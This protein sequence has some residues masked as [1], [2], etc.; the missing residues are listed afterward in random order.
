MSISISANP[1]SCINLAMVQN[2]FFP[3]SYIKLDSTESYENLTLIVN[4]KNGLTPTQKFYV[5]NIEPNRTY[6]IKQMFFEFD[7]FNLATLTSVIT[8]TLCITVVDSLNNLLAEATAKIEVL[9][10]NVVT[11]LEQQVQLLATY[12]TPQ[13]M[14]VKNL[15]SKIYCY[16][17]A[18]YPKLSNI[19]T[20]ALFNLKN[21][22][23]GDKLIADEKNGQNTSNSQVATKE[24]LPDATSAENS[25]LAAIRAKIK[26]KNV[27]NI[28]KTNLLTKDISFDM[29]IIKN[30]K[31]HKRRYGF[32]AYLSLN[33]KYL[34]LEV[35]SIIEYLKSLNFTLEPLPKDPLD[36]TLIIRQPSEVISSKSANLLELTI[37]FNS[38]LE[39]IGI[40]S[41]IILTS[42]GVYASIW[43][44]DKTAQDILV[45]DIKFLEDLVNKDELIII[46]PKDFVEDNN[47]SNKT[48]STNSLFI[49]TTDLEN[50]LTSNPVT[51]SLANITLAKELL[52]KTPYLYH[53]KSLALIN[54]IEAGFI[55]YIDIAAS[56]SRLLS[57][58]SIIIKNK[59]KRRYHKSNNC[60]VHCQ[61][62]QYCYR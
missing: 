13:D 60:K 12:V 48:S 22:L 3:I 10:A 55:I 17:Q 15:I 2:N 41:G 40:H 50:L 53:D 54:D 27:E 7:I 4:W 59:L 14:E 35:Q 21:I 33:Y 8:D 25:N 49:D 11:G 19:V 56:K 16:H 58:P 57:L 47:D 32:L 46:T 29:E 31:D 62:Q 1:V 5:K 45:D 43:L 36:N 44:K 39:G 9:P 23:M 61:Y 51:L 18:K 42:K 6:E 28:A 20:N 52:A 38:L 30:L 26:A 34:L 37:L 24:D